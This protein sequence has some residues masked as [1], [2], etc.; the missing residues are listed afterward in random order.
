MSNKKNIDRLFQEKFKDFES[1]PSDA[2]WSN[3]EAELNKKKKKR[4]IPIWCRYAGV[5]ALLL[6]A[7][8]V[9]NSFF[10]T[11]KVST[12]NSTNQVVGSKTPKVLSNKKKGTSLEKTKEI[13]DNKNLNLK[14]DDKSTIANINLKETKKQKR[15]SKTKL[16]IS[17]KAVNKTTVTNTN[18]EKQKTNSAT[19]HQ[20]KVLANSNSEKD[21]QIVNTNDSKPSN[22]KKTDNTIANT[23]IDNTKFNTVEKNSNNAIAGQKNNDS[24]KENTETIIENTLEKD[25]KAIEDA[26]AENNTLEEKE[27]LNRWSIVPNVAPVYFNSLGE[28]SSIASDLSS[29]SKTGELNMSYGINASYAINKKLIVRSGINRVNLGHNTNDVALI[30]SIGRKAFSTSESNTTNNDAI[31]SKADA[32]SSNDISVSLISTQSLSKNTVSPQFLSESSG[33]VNQAL[34]YIEIPLEFQYIIVDR[35][36]GFNV[37]GGFSSFFLNNNKLLFSESNSSTT[38]TIDLP[39]NAN[40]V[41]YSVNFGLGLNYKVTKK[42][43]LN[44]EPMFKY[45]INTF[46]NTSGYFKPYFIGIY[47][48]VGIKF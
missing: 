17:Q 32:P 42:I 16:N 13:I 3:I 14:G 30:K 34:E 48:G 40:K 44:F 29:N 10:N 6:I 19:N 41:S 5:A 31:L 45:Q 37:I 1:T 36:L 21:T 7:L 22:D 27:N 47:T 20:S 26:I 33:S 4:I 15:S 11:S 2:V 25:T 38:S 8:T 43:N 39:N 18:T 9:V 12:D 28:G 24:E 35:K 23:L 46:N